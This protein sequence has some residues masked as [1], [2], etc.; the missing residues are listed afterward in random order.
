MS[1]ERSRIA[2]FDDAQKAERD[3]WVQRLAGVAGL[4]PALP[5]DRARPAGPG[6]GIGTLTLSFAGAAWDGL[7]RLTKG[8]PFLLYT[9]LLVVLKTCL[10]SSGSEEQ[11]VVVGS[12]AR[13]KE[14]VPSG[15]PNA[16]AVVDRLSPEQSVRELLLGVRTSLVEAYDRQ[17]YPCTRLLRDL[18]LARGNRFPLFD[19]ALCFAGIHGELPDLGNDVTIRLRQE[20]GGVEGVIEYRLDLFVETSIRRLAE[21]FV[22]TAQDVASGL[23]RLLRDLPL[24]TPGERDLL[25]QGW[26]A[27]PPALGAGAGVMELI[28]ARAAEAPG[29][30]ALDGGGQEITYLD[31]AARVDA[32][33]RRL[34]RLGVG[35]ETLVGIFAERSPETIVALLAVLRAGGAY[36]PLDPAWPEARLAL[37]LTDASPA[38]VLA[39]PSQEGRLPPAVR[40]APLTAAEGEAAVA[41]A[42]EPI[43]AA[44][45]SA[46]AYVIYTSGSTGR[47]KG[48][49]VTHAGLSNLALA[50]AAAFGVGPGVRVLQFA[51]LGFDASVSEI[52]CTLASGGTLC[53]AGDANLASAEA[54][55]DLLR[56]RRI[57][58][59]TLPPSLLTLLPAADLLELRTVVSAG[60]A[61]FPEVAAVWA[62]GRR[63]INAYGPTEA[64][65]CA[66]LG[67][68]QGDAGDTPLGRPLAGAAVYILDG[69]GDLVPIQR[70]GELCLA[71]IGLARGYLG[72]PD[73]TAASFVPDPHAAE[74]GARMYRSG[75]RGH[76]LPDGRLAYDGRADQQVKVRGYRIELAEIEAVLRQHPQTEEAVVVAHNAGPGGHRLVAYHVPAPG[77]APQLTELRTFLQERLPGYMVPEVFVALGTLPR[78]ESGK[79]DRRAL[80]APDRSRPELAVR[81]V[82]PRTPL[83]STLAGIWAD[84]LELEQIGVHDSFFELGGNSLLA[85]QTI[86]RARAALGVEID[87]ARMLR[88]PTVA[89]IVEILGEGASPAAAVPRRGKSIDQQLAELELLDDREAAE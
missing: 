58:V 56:G 85:T 25:L 33:A 38:L 54:V 4:P 5:L 24:V 27:G 70:P 9:T 67:V 82:A 22:A 73:L 21:H 36:L 19:V 65:V 62:Q 42:A 2:V 34:H 14:G 60:E 78:N 68:M 20:P 49:A 11:T 23:D 86:S 45:P 44:P 35:T 55:A 59:V 64:T 1:N 53:L 79:I 89:G 15:P 12:P 61:C 47:P 32:E 46:L 51:V 16:V 39:A 57:H 77:T 17:G 8:S 6:G 40:V 10:R 87:L 50:Q 71:G 37:V 31:L 66:A 3:Y 13:L 81:Y 72:R 52:L 43:P 75:D 48:V 63:F 80:P 83:E 7:A 76:W 30:V 74:P 18:D 29:V 69:G 41:G 88:A 28:A 84:L 26:G